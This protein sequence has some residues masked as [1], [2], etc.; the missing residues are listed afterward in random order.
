VLL[1]WTI[2]NAVTL[3]EFQ[4]LTSRYANMPG[5]LVPYGVM[6]WEQT[7]LYRLRE[8][9]QVSWKLNDEAIEIDDIPDRAFD[10][11]QERQHVAA[12]LEQ[13]NNDVNLTAKYISSLPESHATARAPPIAYRYRCK[14]R[15]LLVHS[16]IEQ[17]PISGSLF[18]LA[19][20]W[21]TIA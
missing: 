14:G 16:R 21:A 18:P 7:W 12:I 5:E 3:H 1:P 15:P 6:N 9:F 13:Y 20:N 11:P 10:S 4:P 17:L 2:R 19:E 8:V